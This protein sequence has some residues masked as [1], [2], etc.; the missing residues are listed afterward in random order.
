MRCVN[1]HLEFFRRKYA[2]FTVW[3]NPLEAADV[4]TI[5]EKIIQIE[6]QIYVDWSVFCFDTISMI[7]S[8]SIALFQIT[9]I[10][11]VMHGLSRA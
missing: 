10:T 7:I 5:S 6:L 11:L 4:S 1:F 8:S 3:Q 9:R 2:R